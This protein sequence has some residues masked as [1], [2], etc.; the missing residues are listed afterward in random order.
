MTTTGWQGL[1]SRE[2]TDL[3]L[4]YGSLSFNKYPN[5]NRLKRVVHR[6]GFRQFTAL[7]NGLIGAATG[8]T[9]TATH[10]RIAASVFTSGPHGGGNRTIETI[11]DIGRATTAADVTALKEMLY[12]VVRSPSTYVNNTTINPR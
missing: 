6:E 8:G 5:R 4:G 1:W 11:T 7:F 2:H 3:P 9:V 12:G 10:K